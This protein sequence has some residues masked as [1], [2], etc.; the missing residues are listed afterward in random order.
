VREVEEFLIV[1]VGVNGGHGAAIDAEGFL[2]NL[3]TGARQ[4]W[5]QEALE[6]T[7]CVAGL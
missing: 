2:E 1:G 5:W 6:M 4:W 3:A 7:W